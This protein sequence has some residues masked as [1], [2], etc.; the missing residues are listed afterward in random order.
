[1]DATLRAKNFKFIGG[2]PSLDFA[3]TVGGWGSSSVKRGSRDYR[4]IVLQDKLEGYADLAAWSARAGLLTDKEAGQLIRLAESQPKAAQ[5]VFQRGL[6]LRQAI[7][8]LFKSASEAWQPDA[9]DIEKLNEEL[10][11]ARSHERLVRARNGFEWGWTD[12]GESLDCMLWQL[13]QSTADLLTSSDLGRVGQCGGERCGWF[14]MDTSRNKSR[15]WCDM[16][17]CGNLAKVRRFRDRQRLAS[18]K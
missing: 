4:D 12:R 15:Q 7:Y 13:A 9:S 14:F 17:D 2:N 10:S 11:I 18:S 6:N 1:M 5:A 16:K 3:N 8:R